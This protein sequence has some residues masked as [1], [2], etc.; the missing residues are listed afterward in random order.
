MAMPNDNRSVPELF[1]DLVTQLTTLF[2]KEIQLARTEVSEKVT[3]AAS[4]IGYIVGG[5]VLG[6]AA[7]VILLQ[8]A[9]AWLVRAG[10]PDQWANL[11]VGVVVA[12]I[13]FVLVRMGM[14]SLKADKLTPAKTVEQLQRD[15]TTARE[16]VR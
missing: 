3:V 13:A 12:V 8:A 14:N 15:A 11:I 2:R 16:Q 9:V 6:I 4:G 1:T 5:A 7:L 10:I